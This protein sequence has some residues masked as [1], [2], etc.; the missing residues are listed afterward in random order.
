MT[1][2]LRSLFKVGKSCIKKKN[3]CRGK[4]IALRVKCMCVL[5]DRPKRAKGMLK[6]IL[7]DS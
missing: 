2:I 4:G 3:D 6:V 7:G 5:R 1:G